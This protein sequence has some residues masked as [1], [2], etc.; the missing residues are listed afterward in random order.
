MSSSGS[1]TSGAWPAAPVREPHRQRQPGR[2]AGLGLP[3]PAAVRALEEDRRQ[4]LPPR[5][6]DLRRD[7]RAPRRRRP[8]P[9]HRRALAADPRRAT[10]AIGSPTRS[11][12]TSWSPCCSPATRRRRAPCRGRCTSSAATAPLLARA[13][14]AARTGDDDHLE[15]VLKESMRLHPVIPMVVRTLMRPA[16]VGGWDLP[17]GAT[18]GPSI[19]IAHA[20]ADNHAE[21]ERFDPTPVPRAPPAGQHLDP[22]RWRRTPVHRGGLLADGGRRRAPRDP[23]VVRRDRGP[24][25]SA[26][27]SATSPACRGTARGSG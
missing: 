23:H 6:A 7:P 8:R 3:G 26:R 13:R 20:R 9:A 27:R 22:V 14:E 25:R 5:R 24:A 1:P 21:P 10:R 12:A 19:L 11:S 15:A 18:V 16:T 4:R 2:P 17:A